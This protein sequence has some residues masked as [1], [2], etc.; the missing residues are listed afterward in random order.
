MDYFTA[1]YFPS[2][3]FL[4]RKSIIKMW[5]LLDWFSNFKIYVIFCLFSISLIFWSTFR[6][7]FSNF[8]SISSFLFLQPYF[9]MFNSS[10]CSLNLPLETALCSW[11]MGIIFFL[12]SLRIFIVI[13]LTSPPLAQ[14]IFS[15]LI[16]SCWFVLVPIFQVRWYL[17]GKGNL[18][19][20]PLWRMKN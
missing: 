8:I 13:F 9:K 7:D 11:F 4:P 17:Q 19:C 18:G 14:T 3:F 1:G 15:K 10:Y 12:V 5:Y 20:L 6:D 16:F 2:V